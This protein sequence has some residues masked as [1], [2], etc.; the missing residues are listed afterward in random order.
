[1]EAFLRVVRDLALL[2]ARIIT[3]VTLVA[4]GWHR[5]TITGLEE[6]ANILEGVGLP[7]AEGLVIATIAFELIGGALLVFGLATPLIGLGMIVQN[8]AV[9]LTTRADQG[10]FQHEGGWE[11]NA[12]LA[13]LGLIFLA[14]GCGRAGLDHL[15]LRPKDDKSGQLIATDPRDRAPR[16]APVPAPAPEPQPRPTAYP[17]APDAPPS[18]ATKVDEATQVID[19]P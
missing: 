16:S 11:Y 14:F 1:M 5:W 18:D 13:G 17:P 4:H 2:V 8:V 9:I 7:S 10:F 3:G 19:R 6:Q 15:F 12:I